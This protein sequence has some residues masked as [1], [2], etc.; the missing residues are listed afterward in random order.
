MEDHVANDTAVFPK[1]FV[2]LPYRQV[3]VQPYSGP[4]SEDAIR[5]HLLG[6][7]SYRRTHF[8][9]L[10]GKSEC[11]IAYV[12]K[13]SE[14]PLFSPITSVGILALPETCRWAEDPQVDTGN[15][16]A[17]AG[18]ARQLGLELQMTLIV[19]GMDGHVNF[20]Y[21]PD[22]IRI[23]VVDVIPPEPAKL[24]RMAQQVLTYADLPAIEVVP[25]VIHLRDLAARQPDASSYLIPCRAS[26][27]ALDAPIH[28]LDEH[29]AR[30]EWTMIACE[31]SRQI[32]RHFY[33]DTA[34]CIEM[35][36]RLIAP[37]QE[38]RQL[39]KCCLLE[40]HLEIAETRAVV[41]WGATLQDVEHA[42][43]SLAV[44]NGQ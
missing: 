1:N 21:R 14:E 35:C 11:A 17:L 18:K 10:E 38:E 22:P 12:D 32:H 26:G 37:R 25:S 33:N 42:L 40:E 19:R 34:P 41:P 28:F 2:P 4:W 13:V 30:Q 9:I 16:S 6:K 43:R 8:V 27:L 3:S 31:R 23:H 24:V 36:P 29:P 44:T 39:V 5:R 7:D 20:I 15:R